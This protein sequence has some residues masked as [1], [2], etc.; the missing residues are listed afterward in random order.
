MVNAMISDVMRIRTS[1][2][3]VT[4]NEPESKEI[5]GYPFVT[6]NYEVDT[7]DGVYHGECYYAAKGELGFEMYYSIQP[8]EYEALVPTLREI[9]LSFT[10]TD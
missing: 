1:Q 4:F 5:N 7:E 3:D 8:D 9:A 10:F 2:E 6:Q